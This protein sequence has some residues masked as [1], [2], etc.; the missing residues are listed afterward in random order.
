[1]HAAEV[2][3]NFMTAIE[4]NEAFSDLRYTTLVVRESQEFSVFDEDGIPH[5]R[6]F[7]L[8]ILE[9]FYFRRKLKYR[10]HCSHWTN[11]FA[12]VAPTLTSWCRLFNQRLA[13][14][15]SWENQRSLILREFYSAAV[16]VCFCFAKNIKLSGHTN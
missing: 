2:Y 13:S 15:K 14:L 1:M 6:E 10:L 12:F 3:F 8:Q 4:E 5:C 11:V 9:Y 7:A 16:R